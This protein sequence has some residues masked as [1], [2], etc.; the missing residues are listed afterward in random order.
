MLH[1]KTVVV[2]GV[3]STIGSSNMDWRSLLHNAEANVVIVDAD[4]RTFERAFHR[5]TGQCAQALRK[6]LS[7]AALRR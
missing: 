3:W 4:L 6:Q 7:G 5:H 2:D 1:A